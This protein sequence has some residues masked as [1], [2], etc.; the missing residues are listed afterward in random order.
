MKT[1][2]TTRLITG[3]CLAI[4][5]GLVTFVISQAQG[6]PTQEAL[7]TE[8]ADCHEEIQT[9][10]E[11]S[12]HGQATDDQEFVQMWTE[13]GQPTACLSCHTTGYDATTQ[14]YAAAG[15]TCDNCHTLIAN[16]PSHPEQVMTTDYEA[17]SCGNCHVDTYAQWQTSEHGEA[18]MN[19]INCHN[20]HSTSI[21]TDTVQTLCQT[22]H[23]AESHFYTFTAHAEE[24]LLCT[25]CH[26]KVL[27]GDMGEGHARREHTFAVDLSTCNECHEKEMHEPENL[28]TIE[29]MSIFSDSSGMTEDGTGTTPS[30]THQVGSL[31]QQPQPGSYLNFV[32]L[33]GL[34][35]L[36]FGA[37][38]SPWFERS[39]R[40]LI[41]G[42]K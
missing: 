23:T 6:D 31:Q 8:C 13:K 11:G 41:L 17:A 5:F 19:C 25:D 1:S 28:E 15:I 21:K 38:G 18:D 7:P 24:G 37:I 4:L 20:A 29:N 36:A 14:N 22:C 12:A 39:L 35:G 33:A 16:G 10:W 27:E 26:L 40:S 3:F 2:I 9:H 32:L 30:S 42:V 34:V